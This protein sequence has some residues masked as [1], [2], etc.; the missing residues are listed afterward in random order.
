MTPPARAP[1]GFDA[2]FVF[3][4]ACVGQ[5]AFIRLPYR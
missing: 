3:A 2:A 4:C 5:A 1:D